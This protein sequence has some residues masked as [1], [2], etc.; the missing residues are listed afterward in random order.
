[1]QEQKSYE[2]TVIRLVP[3]VERA[4]FL[5]IG[6]ML[7]CREKKFLDLRFHLDETKIQSFSPDLDLDFIEQ[8]LIAFGLICAGAKEGGLLA[9]EPINYRFRWLAANRST[10]LQCSKVHTGLTKDPKGTLNDLLR[11]MVL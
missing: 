1:M 6:V 11:K 5:N 2:Y 4:E 9:Q 7:Y 8:Q 3:C 10:I